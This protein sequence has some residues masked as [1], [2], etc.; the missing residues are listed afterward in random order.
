VLIDFVEFEDVLGCTFE[1]Y[2]FNYSLHFDFLKHFIDIYL[3]D[4]YPIY[5]YFIVRNYKKISGK[6]IK[7]NLMFNTKFI[8]TFLLCVTKQSNS[9]IAQYY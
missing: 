4:A 7:S 3:K 5:F 8:Y 6:I 9:Y 1:V 2:F